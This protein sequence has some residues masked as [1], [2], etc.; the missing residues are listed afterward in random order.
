MHDRP[1]LNGT[2]GPEIVSS[3]TRICTEVKKVVRESMSVGIQVLSGMLLFIER[4]LPK[5]CYYL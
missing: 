3:M 2:V 1:Y 5:L 4:S